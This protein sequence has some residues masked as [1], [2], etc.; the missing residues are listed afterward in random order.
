MFL[1]G[2]FR[3]KNLWSMDLITGAERQLSNLPPDL[4]IRDFD[5]SADG[6]DVV[7]E[8]EQERSEVV[9]LDLHR[10]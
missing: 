10:P 1:Q 5:L 6:H 4:N 3:H 9:L 7:L 2:E 8:Q